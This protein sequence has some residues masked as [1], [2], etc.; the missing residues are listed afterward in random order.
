MTEKSGP[1]APIVIDMGQH[2][3]KVIRAIERGDVVAVAEVRRTLDEVRAALGD[4]ADDMELVPF[5]V[6][7]KT[8]KKKR[9]MGLGLLP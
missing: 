5:V 9:S 2:K 7:Y 6:V 3:K 8:K 1:G 4:E